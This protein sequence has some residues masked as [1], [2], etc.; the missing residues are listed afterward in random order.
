[1]ITQLSEDGEI[2]SKPVHE[3]IKVMSFDGKRLVPEDYVVGSASKS[4]IKDCLGQHQ[5][6]ITYN[7]DYQPTLF[8]DY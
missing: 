2:K 1:L 8:D 5:T 3:I 6:L 4:Y 7:T